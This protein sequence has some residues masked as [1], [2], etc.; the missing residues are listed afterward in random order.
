MNKQPIEDKDEDEVTRC[1]RVREEL[2]KRFNTLDEAFAHLEKLAE[3]R[4]R[5]G[6]KSGKA[7]AARKTRPA[8][9]HSKAAQRKTVHKETR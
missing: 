3:L 7:R 5:R 1:R 9:N 6:V 8:A 4:K 2:D